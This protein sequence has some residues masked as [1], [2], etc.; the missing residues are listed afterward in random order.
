MQ[1]QRSVPHVFHDNSKF[2]LLAVNNI[3]TDLPE[4][5]LFSFQTVLGSCPACL[6]L[7]S[8]SGM[9][10]LDPFASNARTQVSSIC[11]GTID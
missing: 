1:K 2:A 5:E 7:T 8:A 6:S 4:R 10:G 3:Y 9:N 11:G